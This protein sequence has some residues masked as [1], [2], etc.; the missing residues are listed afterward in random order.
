MNGIVGSGVMRPSLLANNPN[1]ARFGDGQYLSDVV[2]GTMT[3]NQLSRLFLGMPFQGERFTNYVG[4]NVRGLPLVMGR[5]HV[6]V[7]P[8]PGPLYVRDRITSFGSN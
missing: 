6:Y 5:P 7:V 8:N 3:P 1:D 4:I 2:P